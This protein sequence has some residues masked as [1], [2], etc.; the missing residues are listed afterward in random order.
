MPPATTR[1]RTWPRNACWSLVVS[2]QGDG[3]PPD[4]A[5]G[6]IEFLQSRRAPKLEQLSFSVLA[7]GDS[8]YPKFCETGRQVDERLAALGARRLARPRRLRRRLRHAR[9]R[10]GSIASSP[11]RV[12]RWAA[13]AG[14]DR[15]APARGARRTA[16][17]ARA[18]VR[19]RSDR[20]PRAHGARRDQ[21]SASP[22][23]HPRGLRPHATSRATRS[24]SGTRI[25]RPSSPTCSQALRLDG[26][27]T[28]EL[29]G[30]TRP[31]REWLHDRARTHAPDATVPARSRPSARRTRG[32][33]TCCSPATRLTCAAR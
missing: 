1:S 2:T 21:G 27:Q 19:G 13:A 6:L 33:P 28:V 22:R 31:L 32:W 23:D 18:A 4:D 3:D 29:D 25:R 10:R 15:H 11:A 12:T 7:L 16:V 30:A 14:R 24:A 9:Q 20:E 26:E 8:S 5:R 17:L